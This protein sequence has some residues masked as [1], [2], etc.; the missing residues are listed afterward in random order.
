MRE[1]HNEAEGERKRKKRFFFLF[2]ILERSIWGKR[3]KEKFS[4]E[5]AGERHKPAD[6][7]REERRR[8]DDGIMSK[9]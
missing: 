6:K 8:S 7:K 3:G 4:F 5:T 9:R 2:S 1:S